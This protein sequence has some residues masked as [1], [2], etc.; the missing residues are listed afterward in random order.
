LDFLDFGGFWDYVQCMRRKEF[1]T[2]YTRPWYL[3]TCLVQ[4]L[5]KYEQNQK[6]V[7]ILV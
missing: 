2:L 5:S 7:C 3:R 1:F 4:Y 6:S